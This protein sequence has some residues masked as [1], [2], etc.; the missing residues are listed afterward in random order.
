[1]RQHIVDSWWRGQVEV[2]TVVL[3]LDE[4]AAIFGD[5]CLN[6]DAYA[7]G[8]SSEVPINNKDSIEHQ[9]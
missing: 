3:R 7:G 5:T 8:L 4:F 9:Y 6:L 2:L 1:M